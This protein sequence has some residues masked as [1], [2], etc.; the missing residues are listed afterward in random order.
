[1][2]RSGWRLPLLL[3][4]LASVTVSGC[5]STGSGSR[6]RPSD[7]AP[8]YWPSAGR[9]GRAAVQAL[10]HPAT[11]AP[12]A[13]AAVTGLVGDWDEEISDWAVENAPVFDTPED[14]RRKSDQLRDI[15]EYSI[16]V[17]ALSVP[18]ARVPWGSRL[19][20]L[21]VQEGALYLT[22]KATS[23]LKEAAD[24]ERPDQSDRRSFP[25]GHAS[26]ASVGATLA[27]QN[28]DDMG[29]TRPA[30]VFFKTAMVAVGAGT[31]WARV[32]GGKHFPSDILA[33]A[34]LGSFIG[35]FIH[36]AFLERPRSPFSALD[37]HVDRETAYVAVRL[38]F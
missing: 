3:A 33:G 18:R 20:R 34:A 7:L 9:W 35:R 38:D 8:R 11:W 19:G 14:A 4:V 26:T 21:L 17:T 15:A 23:E 31:A 10:R 37:L 13:G 6:A 22:E 25:S 24:R 1:M 29:L 30:R 28:F 5:A 32:E 16:V 12:A 27:S 36:G 2:P